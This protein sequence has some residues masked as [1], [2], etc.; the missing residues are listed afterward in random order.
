MVSAAPPSEDKLV[1]SRVAAIAALPRRLGKRQQ[2]LPAIPADRPG[3]RRLQLQEPQHGRFAGQQQLLQSC[4]FTASPPSYAAA[5]P[6][7]GA[8][9]SA[10]AVAR[11]G[12]APLAALLSLAVR[13][14]CG[15]AR[16]AVG[17]HCGL[18][19][20]AAV[21]G[22]AGRGGALL[23]VG[24]LLRLRQRSQQGRQ[25]LVHCLHALEDLLHHLRARKP[26]S[27]RGAASMTWLLTARCGMHSLLVPTRSPGLAALA[28]KTAVQPGNAGKWDTCRCHSS[29]LPAHVFM[30]SPRALLTVRVR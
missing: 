29:Q 24:L 1:A 26:G 8:A 27:A 5:A 10:A 12:A 4:L 22:G 3:R 6:C 30:Q 21:T 16:R 9:L 11:S 13:I 28:C 20:R 2:R 17:V 15:R 25:V 18:G 23:L 7:A 14:R 19:R